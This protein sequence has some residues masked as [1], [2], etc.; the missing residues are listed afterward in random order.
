MKSV[1]NGPAPSRIRNHP[2]CPTNALVS[3]LLQMLERDEEKWNPVFLA[4]HA[5][6]EKPEQDDVSIKHHPALER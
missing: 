2:G 3:E 4:N 1:A 6:P 5:I